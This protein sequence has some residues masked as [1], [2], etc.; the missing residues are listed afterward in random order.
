MIASSSAPSRSREEATFWT[1]NPGMGPC[2]NPNIPIS[3]PLRAHA[4]PRGLPNLAE[5]LI[6]SI[7]V[8]RS[9]Y[10]RAKGAMA[11]EYTYPA[12]SAGILYGRRRLIPTSF[13]NRAPASRRYPGAQTVA[14]RETKSKQDSYVRQ[15]RMF[16]QAIS[17]PPAIVVPSQPALIPFFERG[18]TTM[19]A[20]ASRTL[21]HR[22]ERRCAGH[23]LR[24]R[25]YGIIADRCCLMFA[26][27]FS[28]G[29]QRA[30]WREL[31]DCHQAE[32]KNDKQ[33]DERRIS[34]CLLGGPIMMLAP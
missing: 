4:L 32:G 15:H 25:F 14:R 18:E 13:P 31:G 24:R 5:T 19:P 3:K 33:N 23:I 29:D 7:R 10:D 6:H 21:S 1:D 30:G 16:P 2:S 34:F 8:A 20:A 27:T 9:I 17:S 28:A 11:L 26:A 22:R 12:A